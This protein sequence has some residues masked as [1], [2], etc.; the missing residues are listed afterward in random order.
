MRYDLT[1][2]D[3]FITVAQERNLTRAAR[4]KHLAVSAIS[5]RITELEA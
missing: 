5:K 1:S 3:L 2:L 4:I